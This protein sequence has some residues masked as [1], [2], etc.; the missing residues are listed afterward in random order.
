MADQTEHRPEPNSSTELPGARSF[1]FRKSFSLGRRAPGDANA[2]LAPGTTH[3]FEWTWDPPGTAPASNRQPAT[4]YEA[5]TGKPDPMR[6]F[7]VSAR[8][9]LNAIV[10]VIAVAIP[11]G[12]VTLGI[13]V[14]ADLQT[15]VVMG[16]GGLVVGAMLKSTFPRTPF[17]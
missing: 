6:G 16:I 7:F 2:G 15:I 1:T 12:L 17:G 13:V 10:T 9:T 11:V 8:R 3:R 14:G 5:L 4:Y